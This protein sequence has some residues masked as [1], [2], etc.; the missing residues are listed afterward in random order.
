MKKVLNILTIIS[1]LL[2]F[3]SLT[4]MIIQ[5]NNKEVYQCKVLETYHDQAAYRVQARY[6]AVVKLI[7]LSKNTSINLS[8]ESYYSATK[9]KESGK[10]VGYYFSKRE[11]LKLMNETLYG[12]ILLI[13]SLLLIGIF[14]F[15]QIII[16]WDEIFGI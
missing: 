13:I 15:L 8:P 11:I 3:S 4:F 14:T 16:N 9:Y 7:E 1:L 6:I 5:T 10:I 12:D 2:F